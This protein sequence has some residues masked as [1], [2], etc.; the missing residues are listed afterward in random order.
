MDN[1]WTQGPSAGD[2][3]IH[4]SD[5]HYINGLFHHYWSVN[6]WGKDQHVVHIGH[7]TSPDILGPYQE[8]NKQE[9][10]ANRIDP[11]LFVDDDGKQYL[12]MVKFTEGNTIWARPMKDPFSFAGDPHYLISSLPNSWE[13]MDHRVAEGPWVIKYRNKYYL[14]YNANHTSTN[15]GNYSL[16]VAE[17]DS[18]LGFN[19]GNKYSHPVLQSNQIAIEENFVDLLG[20]YQDSSSSFWYTFD[21][22]EKDWKDHHFSPT[23][24]NKGKLGFGS[25]R[26]ENSTT[27]RVNTMWKSSVLYARQTLY[28]KEKP[29]KNLVLR[30]HHD[31]DTKVWINGG[32]VYDGKGKQYRN[33]PLD[34]KSL[35]QLNNGANVIA[36]QSS[37]GERS[38]FLDVALLDMENQESDEILFSPGQPNLLRGPNGFEWW[39]IYMANKNADKRGQYINRVHF[40][41]KKLVVEGITGKNTQGYHPAPSSPTFRDLFNDGQTDLDSLKWGNIEGEWVTSNKEAIQAGAEI[42]Q[43]L[44]KSIPAKHYLFEVGIRGKKSNRKAGIFAWWQDKNHWLKVVLDP[45]QKE[46]AY[47]LKDGEKEERF[48]FPLPDDFNYQV[49]HS[50]KVEKNA[51]RFTIKIDGIPAPHHP[52]IFIDSF[53][54]KGLPGIYTE[55]PATFDGIIYTIGWDEFDEKITGWQPLPNQRDIK[56]IWSVSEKGL[57]LSETI[58]ESAL[59]KGDELNE[60]ELSLQITSGRGIAGVYP[61]YVDAHNFV[62]AAFDFDNQTLVISGKKNGRKLDTRTMGLE[63]RHSYYADIRYSDFIEKHF[64][65][66]TPTYIKGIK[67]NKTPHQQPDTIIDAISERVNIFYKNEGHWQPLTSYRESYSSHPSFQEISFEPIRAEGLKFVNRESEDLNYYIYKIGTHEVY[68][69]SFN[70]KVVRIKDA[71]IFVVDGKKVMELKVEF[72]ASKV[73]IHSTQGGT[74]FNGITQFH[75]N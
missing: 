8:P 55:G 73:G 24:W 46:W 11:H 16:G 42:S 25:D 3:Q 23:S 64:T 19:Q 38:S 41:N 52:E 53:L 12:Y 18:P 10:F 13:T 62:K 7:A 75:L 21:Q 50:L 1:D 31:G 26:V 70:L 60:Y 49:Y 40:Y 68:K 57:M 69:D 22:P 48:A 32:L 45:E 15:W 28:L 29:S 74:T 30:M 66:E 36:I 33:W 58:G 2:D 71:V 72:P 39:L 6:Y 5:I 44:I 37:K 34:E 4:A 43:A 27:R 51:T 35:P 56:E 20:S 61:I 63:G 65:F 54:G 17:A 59:F 47:L 67:L 9:W 14:T